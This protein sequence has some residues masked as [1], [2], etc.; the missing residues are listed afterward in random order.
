MN[1]KAS[2]EPHWSIGY[3]QCRY[4]QHLKNTSIA[5]NNGNVEQV[6]HGAKCWVFDVC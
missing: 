3:Q 2:C 4:K 5:E 1:Q 6:P